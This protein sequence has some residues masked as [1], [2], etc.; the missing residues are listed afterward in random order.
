MVN[1]DKSEVKYTY[2][3]AGLLETI[4]EKESSDTIFSNVVNNFDYAPLGE[5]SMQNNA[6]GTTTTNTYDQAKLY[7]LTAKVTTTS[8]GVRLQDLNYTYDAI[9]NILEL[10]ENGNTDSKKKVVYT[11]DDLNRLTGATATNIATGEQI[12]TEAFTYDAL[13]NILTKRET[14]GSDPAIINTYIYDGNIGASYANP[15]AVTSISTQVGTGTPT[16]QTFTYDNNG[17]M[18]AEGGKLYTFDYKNRLIQTSV[19]GVTPPAPPPVTTSFYGMSGDG[20]I[21]YNASTSWAIAHDALTGN[22]SNY[23]ATTFKVNSG[24]LKGG[25]FNIERVFLPFDTSALPDNAT[26]TDAKLKIFTDAKLDADNDGDDWVSVVQA[27]QGSATSLAVADYDLAGSI[28]NPAEGIDSTER[29]DITGVSTA[30]YLI[31]KLN[32][33]GRNWVSKTATTKLALREGH[34]MI[35][36]SF[37][38]IAGI[39]GVR[40]H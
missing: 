31:F 38:G 5:V 12:Y 36:S 21:S 26:V 10:V 14:S 2:N 4:Q 32:S 24:S 22:L 25:K 3:T 6:N 19:P 33:V 1:P 11:Y 8:A 18:I 28:N 34:D 35:N 39:K 37:V 13:G 17:N 27:S 9:G 29:K 40:Y 23:T 15:H 16:L 30:Q 20:S 7:R